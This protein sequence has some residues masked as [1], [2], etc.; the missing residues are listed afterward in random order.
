MKQASRTVNSGDVSSFGFPKEHR[1]RS[2]TDFRQVYAANVYAADDVLVVL[3]RRTGL[4]HAR[5]GLAVSRRVGNA[6][7]RNR[8]KRLIREAFRLQWAEL[9]PGT[10]LVVRP[11]RG[12][13]PSAEA[14][15][16]SLPRLAWRVDKRLRSR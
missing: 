11:R 7:V 3:G 10:D 8:W 5:L 14:I 16:R 2:R 6:V 1:I 13:V 12:A 15:F 4:A 9:P